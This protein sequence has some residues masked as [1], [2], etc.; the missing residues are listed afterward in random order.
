VTEPKSS[1]HDPS[2]AITRP[3]I[4]QMVVA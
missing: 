3:Q 4:S 1:T 2:R